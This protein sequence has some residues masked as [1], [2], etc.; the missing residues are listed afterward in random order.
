MIF[1]FIR[2]K[3]FFFGIGQLGNV[4]EDLLVT[5]IKKSL[6][7]FLRSEAIEMSLIIKARF[8]RHFSNFDNLIKYLPPKRNSGNYFSQNRAFIVR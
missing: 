6:R 2:C 7:I 5:F 1:Q 4:N 3:Y 8:V